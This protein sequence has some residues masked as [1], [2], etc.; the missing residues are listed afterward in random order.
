MQDAIAASYRSAIADAA[1]ARDL[2][3]RRRRQEL[4]RLRRE[5]RRIRLRDYFPPPEREQAQQ[6]VDEL[7]TLVEESVA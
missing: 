7:A 1:A 5:L 3:P 6:A 2:P 4:A